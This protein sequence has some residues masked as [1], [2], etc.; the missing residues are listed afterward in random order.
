[1][2]FMIERFRQ[3]M[4]AEGYAQDVV[5]AV[6]SVEFDD[7]LNSKRKIEALTEFRKATD[8]ETLGAAFKR[9]VNIVKDHTGNEV[10]SEHFVE[11]AEES[12]HNSL[13]NVRGK[14]EA[15]ILDKNYLDSLLIM[16]ELKEPVDK[17]FDNV[18]VMDEDPKIKENRL[19]M[20]AEIKNLFFKI[21][22]FS[23]LSV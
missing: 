6:V 11:T 22:D 2:G 13:S 23:K 10:L 14:V 16:Q 5:E 7:I 1:M 18:M 4:I 15:K 20:L 8:F 12:L 21:A 9:V 17:F 3:L 19:T